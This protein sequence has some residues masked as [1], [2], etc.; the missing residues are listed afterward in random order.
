MEPPPRPMLGVWTGLVV[1]GGVS[2]GGGYDD[3]SDD[4][5]VTG[6]G[7][8][9]AEEDTKQKKKDSHRIIEELDI[10][11][12]RSK[13]RGRGVAARA[14]PREWPPSSSQNGQKRL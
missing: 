7:G 13:R 9:W 3:I 14:M 10:G 8:C 6:L 1:V 4:F 2:I 11:S 5:D 12:S